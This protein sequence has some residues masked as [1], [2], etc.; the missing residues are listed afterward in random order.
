MTLVKPTTSVDGKGLSVFHIMPSRLKIKSPL[1]VSERFTFEIVRTCVKFPVVF[2]WRARSAHTA[3]KETSAAKSGSDTN[4]RAHIRLIIIFFIQYLHR[5][6]RAA[7]NFLIFFQR[8]LSIFRGTQNTFHPFAALPPS[9]C[10]PPLSQGR[11][12]SRCKSHTVF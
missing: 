12:F 9:A 2:G 7:V 6:F 3:S 1:D 8:G 4:T 11:R 5:C 10:F